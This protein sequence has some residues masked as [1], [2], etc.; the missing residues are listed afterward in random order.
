MAAVNEARTY[1]GET[2]GERAARR[3]DR[4]VEATFALVADDGWRG[5]RIERICHRAG[6]NKRYFYESFEDLD[7]AVG[8]L[9]SKLAEE[10]IATTVDALDPSAQ[11]DEWVR[12]AVAAL[13]G[14]AIDDPR[15]ARVLFGATPAGEAA[16]AHRTQA[17]RRIAAAAAAQGRTYH[18]IAGDPIVDLSADLLVGGTSHALLEWLDGRI[19]ISRGQLID[20]LTVLWQVV[21]RGAV[22]HARR[23]AS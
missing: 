13:V 1:A 19:D 10:A 4:L 18:G 20:D 8:A 12:A 7:A 21:R 11:P 2:G 9:M 3:R 17:I 5:L 6:L 16:S 22:A 23:R 15:R 14:Y